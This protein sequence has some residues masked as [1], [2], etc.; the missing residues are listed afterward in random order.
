[1]KFLINT[2]ALC[3]CFTLGTKAQ[4]YPIFVTDQGYILVE[5]TLC[6]SVRAN[7]ILDTGAGANVLSQK[8]FDKIAGTA[9]ESGHFTGFRHDG[10]RIDGIVYDL[11]SLA[12]GKK[13]QH[14]TRVGIYPPLDSY[15]VEGLVSMKFFEDKPFTID[16]KNKRLKF[17]QA[18][19]LEAL[20]AG[21]TVIPLSFGIHTDI[22]L[23]IFIP[24][25]LNDNTQVTALFDTGSGYGGLI[26]HPYYLSRL[27][28]DSSAVE[29]RP[30]RTPISQK[31]QEDRIA[32]LRSVDLCDP[33]APADLEMKDV[34]ATFR[35]GM[36]HEALMGSGMFR[37]R[38]FT[39]D[40]P[41]A[42]MII[43]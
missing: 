42:R 12:I 9:E 16:L 21:G 20:A 6:D 28:I 8:T 37:D 32:A 40:I 25:C 26:L 27:G 24:L 3:F 5:V 43:H 7:F 22:A 36:I 30:Y 34:R 38:A 10:D 31:D 13:Q 4:E 17:P 41:G 35:D 2:F 15:G 33:L 18:D 39:I 14:H 19:E 23:D 1:M 11:P 29:T